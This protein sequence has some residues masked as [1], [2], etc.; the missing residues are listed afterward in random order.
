MDNFFICVANQPLIHLVV[1]F[2]MKIFSLFDKYWGLI[3]LKALVKTSGIGSFYNSDIH[4]KYGENIQIGDYVKIGSGCTLGAM[5]EIKIGNNVTISKNVTIE[6]AGLDMTT[7]LPH[8]HK[9]KPIV[10]QDGVW[11]ASNVI[12]LGGVNIGRNC[13]IGAGVVLT[14]DVAE[15]N[16]I[17]GQSNRKLTKSQIEYKINI[18]VPK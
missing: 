14:K 12:I 5:N 15:N 9:A 7:P 8:K 1:K 16:V 18:K 3:R 2:T 6:T 17:V 10:I 13:V 4:I 11:I